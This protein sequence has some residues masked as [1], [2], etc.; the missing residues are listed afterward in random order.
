MSATPLINGLPLPPLLL[1]LLAANRWQSPG[2]ARVAA[3]APWLGYPVDFLTLEQMQRETQSLL[4]LVADQRLAQ[5]FC[6][7]R[8]SLTPAPI[9]LPWL[10]VERAVL[11][12]VNRFAGD[13]VAIVLD[14]RTTY[15]DPRVVASCGWTDGLAC[16]SWRT[17]APT[18]SVCVAQLGLAP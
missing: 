14:F 18:L 10:D 2:A 1:R 8:Q 4:R 7:T 11:I 15:A 5:L 6:A 17:A 16:L 13:D 3:L 9:T 12:A